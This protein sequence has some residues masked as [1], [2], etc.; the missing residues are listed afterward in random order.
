[1]GVSEPVGLLRYRSLWLWMILPMVVMQLGIYHDYW[2]DFSDNAWAVHVHYWTAT[3]WYVFLILQP[4]SIAKGDF[5]SHRTFGMIGMFLSGGVALTALAAL[6]RD[7]VSAELS[8]EHRDQFGPFV[9]E[10]FYGVAAI[11]LVM[12]SAFIFAIMQAIRFR[13]VPPEHAWWMVST[14]FIIMMPTLGRGLQFLAGM[15]GADGERLVVWP[16]YVTSAVIIGLLLVFAE[17]FA[18]IHHPAT[19]LA[20]GVNVLNLFVMPIGEWQGMQALLRAMIKG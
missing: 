6:N 4:W 2:G 9:P 19:W 17:R 11:E 1:M 3:L 18:R 20:A 15:L 13:R 7:M 8:A 5:A 16:V 10:F 14:V 12:M